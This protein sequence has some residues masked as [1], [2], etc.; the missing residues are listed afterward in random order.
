MGAAHRGVSTVEPP[1][2]AC[3]GLLDLAAAKRTRQALLRRSPR[4]GEKKVTR[5]IHQDDSG[6]GSLRLFSAS[7]GL[8]RLV[9]G[10][11]DL[12]RE[13]LPLECWRPIQDPPVWAG[14]EL[15]TAV[16]ITLSGT[17][18]RIAEDPACGAWKILGSL[19]PSW[20]AQGAPWCIAYGL[21][22]HDQQQC[23]KEG[24]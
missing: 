18:N 16:K 24:T 13:T 19:Q 9:K 12:K 5:L 17:R 23:A 4:L 14:R 20:P 1:F 8:S 22:S 2:S 11:G 6:L 3:G 7:R 10:H 15:S 21:G